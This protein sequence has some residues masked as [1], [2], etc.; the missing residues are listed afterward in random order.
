MAVDLAELEQRGVSSGAYK[1]LFTA[2]RKSPKVQKLIDTIQQR[3]HDGRERNLQDYRLYWAIDLAHETPFAQT[4][5]TL[6]QNLLSKDLT[7]KQV[8]DE[9]KSWG[10]SEKELFLNVDAGNGKFKQV[11]NPPVFYQIFIPIVR[12]Y[13]AA[14]T[15]RIYNDRDTSPLFKYH[16]AKNT[17]ANRVKCQIITDM[18]D[19]T[20]QWYGH[21]EYL[22]QAIQQML[23]YGVTVAFPKEEWHVEEQVIGGTLKVQKEGLRYNMPHPTRMGF[24]LHHPAP[25]IN[26]DTGVEY[27][28]HWEVMRYGDILDNRMYWNRKAITF[29]TN[30]MD[31][32][33]Y[34]NYFSEV[35]PCRLKFPVNLDNGMSREDKA[36]YYSNSERD[37]A[38][39]LTEFFWKLSP[40][41][42]GLG[43]YKYPVW[44]RFTVASDSTIIWAA[45]CA[46]NPLWFM[47][48]DFDAQAGTPCSF[49]LETI[50]WQDHLGNILSQMILTAKQNLENVIFYDKNLVRKEDITEMEN[51]G[52]RRY[53]SRNFLGYDSLKLSRAGLDVKQAFFSPQFQYRSIVELQSMLS[54]AL[55]LMERVLQITAQETGAAAQHYQSKEEVVRVGNS[56]DNRLRYTASSVD[57]GIDAWKQQLYEANM[58]YRDDGITAHVADNIPEL[59]KILQDIGYTIE[60]NGPYKKLVKGSKANLNYVEFVR[61]NVDPSQNQDPQSAQVIFQTIGV[62]ANNPEFLA[63]IGTQ[64]VVKLLEQAA[65]FAGAPDD[66][67]ITSRITEQQA[68]PAFLQQ[69]QPVLQQLQQSIMQAVAENVAKPAAQSAAKQE[70]DIAQLQQTVK[71]LEGIYKIAA[72]ANDKAQVKIM[73]TQQQMAIDQAKFQAEQERM[74]L[75]MQATQ[76]R[77][78]AEVLAA[79]QRLQ[80]E[81][82]AQMRR[83]AEKAQLDVAIATGKA[84]ADLQA[85]QAAAE[86]DIQLTAAKTEANIA[87]KKKEKRAA[88]QTTSE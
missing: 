47:G 58:A 34:R 67:D 88:K 81:H 23:K 40:S 77:L 20:S 55:N 65:K 61:T 5:P 27:A 75:E 32:P 87:L 43:N 19:T 45:P 78:D 60:G 71:Q 36:A 76:Q 24:D 44:H 3:I 48:Y 73:E 50:P 29:G 39:F 80:T 51:L 31:Q 11:L 56:S 82:E 63:A 57:S 16:P 35:F 74:Q 14:K 37:S 52:E 2:D 68:G 12:A 21:T 30:W 22:K 7:A 15:A 83:D 70:Q 38:L 72:A 33:L 1:E 84:A 79:Q 6:V 41:Q 4:T 10:L 64:R 54:T 28:Y 62:V 46:Y 66:F 8:L 25:T 18:V 26:T 69:L 42:W 85:K 9:L 59:D 49:S 17:D 13:H 53:R 86:A